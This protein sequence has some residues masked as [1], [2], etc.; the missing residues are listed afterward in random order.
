MASLTQIQIIDLALNQ[1]QLDS[2]F[3]SKARTW[4]QAIINE[5]AM[6][7]SWPFYRSS[8][9]YVQFI[10]Q[11][12][13]YAL[14]TNYKRPDTLY[15]GTPNE[16]RG[17]FCNILEP[18]EFERV[19]GGGGGF[20]TPAN[21]MINVEQM[22]LVFS[23]APSGSDQGYTLTYFREPAAITI[24]TDN[25]APDFRD[26]PFLIAE[27]IKWAMEFRDDERYQAK[28]AEASIKNN[29]AKKN[30]FHFEN[31]AVIQLGPSFRAGRRR[32]Y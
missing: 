3:R 13:S 32:G 23:Q 2:S 20:G 18:Y 4:L 31:S 28:S 25:Q 22:Q 29:N 30:V 9:G 12:G 21:A 8:T 11:Q 5:Q 14:P 24:G 16:P 17:R 1:A 10:A 15:I 7:F 19:S 27:L 6:D 26:E